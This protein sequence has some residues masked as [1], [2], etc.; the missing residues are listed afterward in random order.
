MVTTTQK[1]GQSINVLLVFPILQFIFKFDPKKPVNDAFALKGLQLCYLFAPII[2][3]LIGAAL[4]FG[5]TLD[6]AQHSV[7]RAALDARDAAAAAEQTGS[8]PGDAPP[9]VTQA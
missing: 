8:A 6:E 5:Y 1:L 3:V 4:F 9:V 7:I 2:F